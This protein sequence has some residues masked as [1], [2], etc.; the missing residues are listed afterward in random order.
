M[1]IIA[2]KNIAVNIDL[3]DYVNKIKQSMNFKDVIGKIYLIFKIIKFLN[4][5]IPGM[6]AQFVTHRQLLINSSK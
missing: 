5:K 6:D 3:T 4:Y 2:E 1:Q